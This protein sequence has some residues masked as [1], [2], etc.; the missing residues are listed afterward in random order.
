MTH[1]LMI[2]RFAL[3]IQ[4]QLDNNF[5][6][7]EPIFFVQNAPNG[8]KFAVRARTELVQMLYTHMLKIV[9]RKKTHLIENN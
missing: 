4:F 3:E 6:G 1:S 9:P 7:S 2:S 8:S 5:S